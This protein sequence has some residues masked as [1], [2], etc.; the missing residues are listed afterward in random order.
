M[1]AGGQRLWTEGSVCG[2]RGVDGFG[3]G[4]GDA[5]ETPVATHNYTEHI[6]P[7]HTEHL[8]YGA[9]THG[10]CVHARPNHFRNALRP[11]DTRA[12]CERTVMSMYPS[13][14]I[15]VCVHTCL[16]ARR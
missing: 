16:Q 4:F 14:T 6:G 15:L 10:A 1:C 13:R 3:D 12:G 7:T 8:T 2:L 11:T 9:D 5:R